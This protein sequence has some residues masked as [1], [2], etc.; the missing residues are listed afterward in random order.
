MDVNYNC[1]DQTVQIPPLQHGVQ[2]RVDDLSTMMLVTRVSD[3]K[4]VMV[5]AHSS[6]CMH[7]CE[8]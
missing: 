6:S 1:S 8:L 7:G 2:L 3:I 5:E 4:C